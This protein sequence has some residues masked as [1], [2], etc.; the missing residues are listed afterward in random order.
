MTHVSV[1]NYLRGEQQSD[2]RH[3]YIHSRVYARVGAS[4]THNTLAL[5]LA[6][7]LKP[8]AGDGPCRVYISDVKIRI[9]TQSE[10]RFYLETAVDRF[11][12]IVRPCLVVEVLSDSTERR[13]RADKFFSYRKLASLTEYVLIAQDTH[14]VEVYRQRG[15]LRAPPRCRRLT[16]TWR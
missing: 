9:H 2:I 14:R 1:E 10:E 4:V 11:A 7:P 5:N 16:T 12:L 13:D 15:L 6:T 8:Q 3:E